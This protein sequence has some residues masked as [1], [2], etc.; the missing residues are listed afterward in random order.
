MLLESGESALLI[1]LPD[2]PLCIYVQRGGGVRGWQD[3]IWSSLC[4]F[5][6]MPVCMKVS[7]CC[8][9]VPARWATTDAAVCACM[10]CR[11]VVHATHASVLSQL[12]DRGIEAV[13]G[14][15]CSTL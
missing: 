14:T 12:H 4:V 10:L 5:V 8:R 15:S 9:G 3:V 7:S 1:F 11:C 13:G 2:E 6:Y